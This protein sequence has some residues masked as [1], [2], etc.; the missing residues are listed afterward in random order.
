MIQPEYS[1]IERLRGLFRVVFIS[2]KAKHYFHILSFLYIEITYVVEV[3]L[4]GNQSPDS[5]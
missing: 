5:I 1:A 2:E 4:R 3:L